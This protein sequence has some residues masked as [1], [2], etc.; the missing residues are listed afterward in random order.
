[1]RFISIEQATIMS[2]DGRYGCEGNFVNSDT[3]LRP[4]NISS[5]RINPTQ[6]WTASRETCADD[7]PPSY[8]CI[9]DQGQSAYETYSGNQQIT[10][11]HARSTEIPRYGMETG[12]SNK[13]GL[14]ILGNSGVG[15]SFLANILLGHEVFAHEVK[16]SSV[17][18]HT[19]FME[20]NIGNVS[21][22]IFDIPGLLEADQS[23]VD[24]N[25][26]EIEKAFIQRSNSIIIYVFG[27][28]NGRIRDEDVVAFKA[29]NTA[30]SFQSRALVI[31]VNGLPRKRAYDYEG[32]TLVLLQ[33]LLRNTDVNN[34]NVCFLDI[35]DP[36]NSTNKQRIKEQLLQVIVNFT[37]AE[38]RKRQEIE[39]MSDR[40]QSEIK[41]T[42]EQQ[43]QFEIER[44]K[45]M[46]EIEYNQELL[47]K[48]IR[49][50]RS[51][52]ES[53]KKALR[54]QEEMFERQCQRFEKELER[55]KNQL[56]V[57]RKEMN[58][59]QMYYKQL[60]ND[61]KTTSTALKQAQD[62]YNELKKQVTQ[63]NTKIKSQQ[64]PSK[65]SSCIIS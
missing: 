28:Q 11:A 5:Q 46:K 15:K 29:I 59:A 30:Y 17:T 63:L 2:R 33:Q 48:A 18:H 64:P 19:D 35:I 22:A 31:V 32:T 49:E 58:E 50:Q 4:R 10:S 9:V 45:Y 54:R 57:L 60:Q 34:T 12:A 16:S 47:N 1:M 21:F 43:A 53:H 42:R 40:L 8:S 23:R 25:K 41:R 61:D 13:Y 36:D 14:I 38:H 44:K 20:I 55:D 51:E 62:E 39:T 24:L 3:S 26:K 27:N 7:Q 52:A 6:Y 65:K 56:E 37:P